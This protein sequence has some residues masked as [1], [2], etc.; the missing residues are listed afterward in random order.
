MT[1]ILFL[2][3]TVSLLSA[4]GSNSIVK[5]IT[6]TT[7]MDTE[8]NQWVNIDSKLKLGS[9]QFPAVTIPIINPKNATELLGKISLAPAADGLN[10][11]AIQA[12]LNQLKNNAITRD[13]LLPNGANI[14]IAGMEGVVSVNISGKSKIYIG[15]NDNQFMIGLAL[16]M[17]GLD[18]A[19][20]YM[21]GASLFLALPKESQVNG[22]AGVFAGDQ[23]RSGLG[24]FVLTPNTIQTLKKQSLALK[25]DL[26][27]SPS[28]RAATATPV[29]SNENSDQANEIK[30][31]LYFLSQKRK[32]LTIE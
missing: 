10:S 9:L 3:G 28:S 26:Q 21:S 31:S 23:N 20:K 30:R 11:L 4:C 8:Q 13:S 32:V 22:V 24:L 19:L 6:V 27:Q 15:A 29:I 2:L 17:P 7:V 14:P 16:V 12:N 1:K 25:A 18:S 5:S